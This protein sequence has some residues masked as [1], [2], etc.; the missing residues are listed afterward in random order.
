MILDQLISFKH[1]LREFRGYN[2]G[3]NTPLNI[4]LWALDRGRCE[5]RI[6]TPRGINDSRFI[7]MT[8]KRGRGGSGLTGLT[9]KESVIL[10][11]T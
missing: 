7:K 9:L 3:I 5:L 8:V 10:I 11:I 4:R 6:A 1:D 2:C